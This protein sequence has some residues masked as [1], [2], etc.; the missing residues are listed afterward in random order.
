MGEKNQNFGLNGYIS[1]PYFTH[2]YLVL[3]EVSNR[4]QVKIG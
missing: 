3:G 4:N 2:F 1:T